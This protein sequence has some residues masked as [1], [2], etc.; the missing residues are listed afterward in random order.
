VASL[1]T[2]RAERSIFRRPARGKRFMH[3]RMVGAVT[4][5]NRPLCSFFVSAALC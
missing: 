4:M 2:A 5:Q 3:N 1:M